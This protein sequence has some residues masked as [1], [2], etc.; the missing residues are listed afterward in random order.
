MGSEGAAAGHEATREDDERKNRGDEDG[1]RVIGPGSMFCQR[2][3]GEKR[4]R[5]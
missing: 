2:L 5:W 4:Q 3:V 1:E